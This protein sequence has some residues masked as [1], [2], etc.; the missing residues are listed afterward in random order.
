MDATLRERALRMLAR[1]DY[2]RRELAR[3]LAG[4]Q[5]STPSVDAVL[6][7]LSAQGLLSDERYAL[8]RS[9]SRSKVLGN[10]R[11]AGELRAKGVADELIRTALS[12]AED[13]TVRARRIWQRKFGEL[14]TNAT[15]YARQARFL[16]TRGFAGETI[17]QILKSSPESD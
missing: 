12:S 8:S 6:E 2:T 11:L 9:H 7:A 4:E 1:R 3:K 17:R 13:E 15:E 14:P 16:A 10:S 5:S